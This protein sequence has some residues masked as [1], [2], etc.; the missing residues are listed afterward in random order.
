METIS[1]LAF[2]NL[3]RSLPESLFP[4][5]LKPQKT[6]TGT[7]GL[8]HNTDHSLKTK[9]HQTKHTF[10]IWIPD[11][12]SRN[13]DPRCTRNDCEFTCQKGE[14]VTPLRAVPGHEEAEVHDGHAEDEG[15]AADERIGVGNF[16]PNQLRQ[17][18]T[19]RNTQ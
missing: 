15:G 6:F 13:S 17:R 1:R 2:G 10:N 9:Y 8:L 12:S 18:W 19:Q 4:N 5:T 7:E 14:A 3:N 11:K 16:V